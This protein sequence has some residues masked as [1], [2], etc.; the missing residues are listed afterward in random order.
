MNT[1]PHYY[2][3]PGLPEGKNQ[4]PLLVEPIANLV[5]STLNITNLELLAGGRKEAVTA[6][7]IITHVAIKKGI[8]DVAL[9]N[10]FNTKDKSNISYYKKKFNEI[11]DKTILQL[12]NSIMANV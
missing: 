2:V 1:L 7:V 10:F 6:R 12:T 9:K 4:S 11:T 3:M 8:R 5:I